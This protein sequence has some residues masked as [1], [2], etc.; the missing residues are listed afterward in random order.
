MCRLALIKTYL[1]ESTLHF[2]IFR[3]VC[4]EIH[5][6]RCMYVGMHFVFFMYV[7]TYLATK[8]KNVYKHL[9]CM[10]PPELSNSPANRLFTVQWKCPKANK[11]RR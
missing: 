11:T 1:S 9:A 5:F 8:W 4:M 6:D 10:S 2:P 7:C 3:T